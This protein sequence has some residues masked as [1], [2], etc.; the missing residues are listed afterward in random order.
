MKKLI[1]ANWKMNGDIHKLAHDLNEYI[2]NSITNSPNVILA[3]PAVF[4]STAQSQLQAHNIKLSAQDV[5]QFV[6][7]GAYTG[8][9]SCN[10]FK[11][12]GAEYVIIG[13]SERRAYFFETNAILLDKLKFWLQ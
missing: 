12:I 11:D 9:I 3:L 4:L 10:M 6:G 1:V 5:S 7:L 8:E 13:H 2:N